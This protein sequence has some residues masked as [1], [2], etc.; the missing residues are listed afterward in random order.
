MNAREVGKQ[1]FCLA[2]TLDI[3][4]VQAL[5]AELLAAFDNGDPVSLNGSKVARIDTAILQLLASAFVYAEEHQCKLDLQS[6][7]EALVESATLLGINE[8][9]GLI[10]KKDTE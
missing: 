10:A 4:T 1:E 2:E 9:I 3:S 8:H 6:P 5:H 7:S